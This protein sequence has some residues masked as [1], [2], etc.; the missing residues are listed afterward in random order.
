[1]ML[2]ALKDWPVAITALPSACEQPETALRGLLA[3]QLG[4]HT[5]EILSWRITQKSIDA[6]RK[7]HPLLIYSVEAEVGAEPKNGGWQPVV[8]PPP[9]PNWEVPLELPA[10]RTA[11]LH[12]VVVGTGPAGLCAAWVLAR[13]GLRPLVLDCGGPGEERER[14]IAAFFQ[15]RQ[16]NPA[17]NYLFGE[18]GAGTYSDGKLY[19]R[20]RDVRARAVLELFAAAGAPEEILYLKRPHIG[21][22]I[23]PCM[24]GNIRRRIET[25]G[26]VFR[27][28]A[29][30]TDIAVE[31]Q[32]CQGVVLRSGERIA[33]PAVIM[34]F[35]HS[36]RP[37]LN[38]LRRAGVAHELKGFQTGCRIEHPQV[39]I[40]RNQY[41]LT[42]RPAC[43]GAAEYNLVSRV[44]ADGGV[45]GVS[46]FCMC[47]GGEIVP[48]T[49]VPGRLSTN[50]MS[51]YR[52]DGEF[53]D[54]CLIMTWG[55]EAFANPE[56]AFA[57]LDDLEARA[58]QAGG[59]DY[60][61]PAQ[62]AAAFLR[63][64]L[65]LSERGGSYRLGMKAARLDEMLPPA[66]TTALQTALRQFD[67]QCRGFVAEGRLVG[68]ETHVSSPVRFLRSG[69]GLGSSLPG[70]YIVGEGA[71]YA[72][73][74]ISA[75]VDG[76]RAAEAYLGV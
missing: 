60:T 66:M 5:N 24:V 71:G 48:A 51:R 23:L 57:L 63:G 41:G 19:T 39:L 7:G 26:G 53:A 44:A 28:H 21:S 6:R 20:I 58:F 27:W 1:M 43:L 70:L 52:R 13:Q 14:D 25:L 4:L 11:P 55:P 74:I 49:A 59:G 47:P 40:D 64:E 8:P 68:V 72:G 67:R 30:V 29:E 12:P 16:L 38:N 15:T 42:A 54:S 50:G 35:G 36:A 61:A 37:L 22:D 2:I 9:A 75:A 76:W 46:T 65:R 56:E 62:D 45:P 18:G 34:G 3:H 31:N 69:G 33:A 73:G 32:V 10:R 17:S